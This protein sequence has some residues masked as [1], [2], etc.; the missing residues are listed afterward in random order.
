MQISLARS[1]LNNS[2]VTPLLYFF[3]RGRKVNTKQKDHITS[4]NLECLHPVACVGSGDGGFYI[5]LRN[6]TIA[7]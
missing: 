7:G 1:K 2:N 3:H 6:V 5:R 4:L